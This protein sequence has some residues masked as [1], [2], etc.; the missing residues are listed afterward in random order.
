ME[1][2]P[3]I[4]A[5][6]PFLVEVEANKTYSWCSCGYTAT[7]PFCDGAHK[8]YKNEDGTSIMKSV[9]YTAQENKVVAFCG[10][11][12]S[13]NAPLCDGSHCNL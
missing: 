12:N 8:N 6:K 3:R 5:I 2:L 4:A 9:K 11:K 13:K 10:C 1:K 7:E